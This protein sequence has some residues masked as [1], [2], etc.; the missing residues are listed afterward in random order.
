M[1]NNGHKKYLAELSKETREYIRG[2][3][4]ST[5]MFE[6]LLTMVGNQKLRRIIKRHANNLVYYTISFMES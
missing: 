1:I 5:C 4:K 3:V 2:I 6:L